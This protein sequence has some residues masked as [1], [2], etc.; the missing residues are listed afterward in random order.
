MEIHTRT[1]Q[2]RIYVYFIVLASYL[3]FGTYLF[4]I[5]EH[6]AS[7]ERREMYATRCLAV[8]N[9]A[10]SDLENEIKILENNSSLKYDNNAYSINSPLHK[11][12]LKLIDKIDECHRN[13]NITNVKE[14]NLLNAFSF[15]YSVS[16]TLG[17]GDIE[18]QTI[19]GKIFFILF[20]MISIPLFIT[21]YVELTE[22]VVGSIVKNYYEIK[23]HIKKLIY[24]NKQEIHFLRNKIELQ[25]RKQLPKVVVS[26][27][28]LII[29]F[30]ICSL[31]HVYQF[32]NIDEK[33]TII[34]SMSFIFESI[35]LIGLGNNVPEDTFNYLT[36]ELPLVFI[37]VC[38]FGIY[39]NT[40]VNIA[41]HVIPTFIYKYRKNK[42][43]NNSFDIFDYILYQP[44]K[45]N[46]GIL[47][48]YRS[49]SYIMHIQ[50]KPSF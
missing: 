5:F 19:E 27:L 29:I 31:N 34:Q 36:R 48:D 44:E 43:N 47:G 15:V 4:Y 25:K 7:I 2:F 12:I 21:F 39:L 20:S 13:H 8:K 41:R 23:F 16:A 9:K 49:D 22:F 10:I 33:D 32:K 26:M 40:T 18:A 28:C 24:S 45:R 38:F 11:N 42:K 37:G 46:L 30:I 14:I 3:G 50:T 35:A 6:D 1:V 17:Y